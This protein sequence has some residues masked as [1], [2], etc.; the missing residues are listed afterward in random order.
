MFSLRICAYCVF[1]LHEKSQHFEHC[2]K[3]ELVYAY[4]IMKANPSSKFI[5]F[6][7]FMRTLPSHLLT[8][9]FAQ[10]IWSTLK[11]DLDSAGLVIPFM[12]FGSVGTCSRVVVR[13]P[14]GS[15]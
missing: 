13:T 10:K 6:C 3:R 5:C 7:T 4:Y 14:A 2:Q 1:I 12:V 15:H 8:E 9:S 11:N